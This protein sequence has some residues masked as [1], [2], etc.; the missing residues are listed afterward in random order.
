MVLGLPTTTSRI[1]LL[2]YVVGGI[3]RRGRQATLA[4]DG[5]DLRRISLFSAG[6]V[7]IEIMPSLQGLPPSK[8]R[9]TQDP[10]VGNLTQ[11]SIVQG[12]GHIQIGLHMSIGGMC[13]G[14]GADDQ[15]LG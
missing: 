3:T 2:L 1:P 8:S 9:T 13:M 15:S 12:R 4:G 7:H 5:Q 11:K 6:G 14:L 10:R